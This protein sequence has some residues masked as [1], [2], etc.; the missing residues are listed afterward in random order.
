M[1]YDVDRLREAAAAPD[2]GL[3]QAQ[4]D[5]FLNPHDPE[6]AAAAAASGITENFIEAAQRSPVYK[7]IDWKLALPPHPEFRTF[8][9]VW[10]IPPLSPIVSASPDKPGADDLTRLRIPL[11]YL[12]NLLAAGDEAPVRLALKR[13]L[14]LR[15]YMRSV[16]VENEPDVPALESVGLTQETAQEMYHLLAL[17]NYRD[18][19]V[20]P[21]VRKEEA[22]NL[23]RGHGE[24]GFPPGSI[25]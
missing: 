3:Y 7:L 16:R 23:Y 10:Y 17:A 25:G 22:A 18:R 14:A 15:R 19:F 11:K 24:A 9:M 2:Q 8:P 20:V 1:L 4:T 13:L 6:V 12:A 5:L 21:T